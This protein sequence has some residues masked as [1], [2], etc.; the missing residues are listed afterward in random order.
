M[1]TAAVYYDG[2]V[3]LVSVQYSLLSLL[4]LTF[5]SP[6]A[7]GGVCLTLHALPGGFA[8]CPCATLLL[9]PEYLLLLLPLPIMS[10]VSVCGVACHGHAELPLAL[11]SCVHFLL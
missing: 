5:F 9:R 8:R 10:F 6:S 11:W 3:A 4:S 1:L 7:C 2:A